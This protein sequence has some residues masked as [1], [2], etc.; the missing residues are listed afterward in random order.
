[1]VLAHRGI[2]HH[3]GGL[4][5]WG[6]AGRGALETHGCGGDL[7][8]PPRSSLTGGTSIDLVMEATPLG[9]CHGKTF[10]EEGGGG[11]RGGRGTTPLA[12]QI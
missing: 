10:G 6:L 11:S 12:F 5:R 1:M 3:F 7:P 9:P 4:R 2:L 8:R